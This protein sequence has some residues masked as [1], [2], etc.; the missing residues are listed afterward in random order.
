MGKNIY[1][2][3]KRSSTRKKGKGRRRL[4]RKAGA[5][6]LPILVS[7]MSL[8]GTNAQSNRNINMMVDK[9]GDIKHHSL[10]TSEDIG[11]LL[12]NTKLDKKYGNYK[13]IKKPLDN[14]I[15]SAEFRGSKSNKRGPS[16]EESS[17]PSKSK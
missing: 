7:M 12:T 1:R 14:F 11:P 17:I 9:L 15:N 6:K 13:N 5:R 2:R 10:L 3:K 8:L 4:T 16:D